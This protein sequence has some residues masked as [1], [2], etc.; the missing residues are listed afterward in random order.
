[1]MSA[2][3]VDESCTT[4]VTAVMFCKQANHLPKLAYMGDVIRIHRAGLE[5]RA[6]RTFDKVLLSVI[7]VAS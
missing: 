1:M 2:V 3:M 7:S 6:A 4:P 5:V